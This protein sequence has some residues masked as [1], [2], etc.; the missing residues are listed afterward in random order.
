MAR[1]ICDQVKMK[2]IPAT[3]APSPVHIVSGV[4]LTVRLADRT[5]IFQL[6]VAM[7]FVRATDENLNT[8]NIRAVFQ[9]PCVG[10]PNGSDC[11]SQ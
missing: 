3:W 4:S 7:R 11:Q 6:A 9:I 1:Y 8:G 2:K 10:L 5:K